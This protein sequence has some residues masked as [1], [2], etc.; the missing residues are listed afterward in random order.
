MALHYVDDWYNDSEEYTFDVIRVMKDDNGGWYL[1]TD[2]GCSCP[3]PFENYQDTDYT[4]PL[5]LEQVLEELP[6]LWDGEDP[7]GFDDFL[8]GLYK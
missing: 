3:M 1:G 2:S 6:A 5:T 4:G 8:E 7:K